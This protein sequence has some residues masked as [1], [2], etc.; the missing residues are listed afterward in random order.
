MVVPSVRPAILNTGLISALFF[1]TAIAVAGLPPLSGFFGKLMILNATQDDPWMATIWTV[2]LATSLI[3]IIGFARAGSILFWKS[4]EMDPEPGNDT[5]E[6]ERP[7]RGPI[8][9]KLETDEPIQ[10][11]GDSASPALAFVATGTLLAGSVALTL[12]AGPITSYL[13]QTA[14]QLTQPELYYESVLRQ[15]EGSR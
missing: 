10:D 11:V 15:Q 4:H 1:A 8:P 13:Q 7:R 9:T 12:F 3:A 14:D 5:D 2:I 6:G